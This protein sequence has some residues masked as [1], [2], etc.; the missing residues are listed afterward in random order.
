MFKEKK[1]K[2]KS[3]E[4]F[5]TIFCCFSAIKN[6]LFAPSFSSNFPTKL[7]CLEILAFLYL[8]KSITMSI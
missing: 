4:K 1:K 5:R 6:I 3:K 2:E 8:N 7:I